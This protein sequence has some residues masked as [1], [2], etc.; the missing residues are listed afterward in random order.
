M[1]KKFV[2]IKSITNP[3]REVWSCEKC[4]KY[5]RIYDKNRLEIECES[6]IYY[7]KISEFQAKIECTAK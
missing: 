2:S 3:V 6:L 5:C 4:H 1:S 7:E